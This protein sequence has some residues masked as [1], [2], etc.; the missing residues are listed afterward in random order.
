MF[1]LLSWNF[2]VPCVRVQRSMWGMPSRANY[3]SCGYAGAVVETGLLSLHRSFR[4][5]RC[6][7]TLSRPVQFLSQSIYMSVAFRQC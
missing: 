1:D 5:A 7:S 4:F 2:V 3:G 6:E